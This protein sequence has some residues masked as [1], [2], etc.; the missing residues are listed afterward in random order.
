[1]AESQLVEGFGGLFVL[2]E[3]FGQV[4]RQAD[5][6]GGR[7]GILENDPFFFGFGGFL[8]IGGRFEAEGKGRPGIVE[9]DQVQSLNVGL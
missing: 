4:F 2:F 6:F 3:G 1:V 5:S 9:G 7:V 8:F